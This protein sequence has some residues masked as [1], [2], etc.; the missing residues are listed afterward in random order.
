MAGTQEC[1]SQTVIDSLPAGA[2]GQC[3]NISQ[4]ARTPG[5]GNTAGG[6]GNAIQWPCGTGTPPANSRFTFT[7]LAN[8][9][10]QIA[11]V[12]SQLCLEDPGS[13]GWI[14]RQKLCDAS[15]PHQQFWLQ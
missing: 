12:G 6:P 10:F 9:A 14:I 3:V 5:D 1:M 11:A 8:G 4:A 15:N 7:K 2:G 13:G